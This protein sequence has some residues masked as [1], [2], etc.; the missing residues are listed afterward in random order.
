VL[1]Q[2]FEMPLPSPEA[3]LESAIAA[4]RLGAAE[5]VR[6]YGSTLAVTTNSHA[7]DLVTQID[8]ASERQVLGALGERW[9]EIGLLAEES[10]RTRPSGE[11]T[12]IVDPLDGT[13]NFTHGY[14]VFCVSI[15]C[16]DRAGPLAGVILDPLRDE[17]YTAIRGAG[18][19]L[20]GRRLRVSQVE[21]P[22]A[23]LFSTGLPY[24]P[25]EARRLGAEVLTEVVLIAGDVRRSGS[26]ALDLA[27]VAAGRSEAHFELNLSPHD[28]AAGLL[29]VS[30]AGGRYEALQSDGG[31]G[32][33][34][35]LLASNGRRLHDEVAS[36]I[37]GP[38]RLVRQPFSFDSVFR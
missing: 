13:T 20:D 11:A 19:F 29:L 5:L 26:A 12:W 8:L 22:G 9:P 23:A 35:G 30:E 6:G 7:R 3:L 16:V 1:Q 17:L 15:G 28:V 27:Y 38:Q 25:P 37:A 34:K 21:E 18:A 10:G 14:P 33:P 24:Y 31:S 36:L 2:E 4:A 32:W